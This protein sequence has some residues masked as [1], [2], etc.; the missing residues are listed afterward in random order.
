M[1]QLSEMILACLY[2][3]TGGSG[4]ERIHFTWGEPGF[5]FF[6]GEG[7]ENIQEGKVIG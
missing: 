4:C 2:C 3:F 6:W 7:Y 5:I 1:K